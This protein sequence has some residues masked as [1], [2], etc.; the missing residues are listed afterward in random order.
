MFS[1]QLSRDVFWKASLSFIKTSSRV[2]M[3]RQPSPPGTREAP[4]A[5]EEGEE[6]HRRLSHGHHVRRERRRGGGGRH[7]G[8]PQL[9]L[10]IP[11]TSL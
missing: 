8:D 9:F 5:P 11:L 10:V 4:Q 6:V 3:L 7:G 2:L 1:G